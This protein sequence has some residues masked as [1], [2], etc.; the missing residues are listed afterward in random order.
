M[1]HWRFARLGYHSLNLTFIQS[2]GQDYM[3][4]ASITQFLRALLHLEAMLEA[5]TRQSP[6]PP[7]GVGLGLE[8]LPRLHLNSSL[9]FF[10]FLDYLGDGFHVTMVLYRLAARAQY[11][12]MRGDEAKSWYWVSQSVESVRPGPAWLRASC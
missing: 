8:L 4:E 12:L 1:I 7:H 2:N 6:P 5:G 10:F 11:H 9:C 3:D